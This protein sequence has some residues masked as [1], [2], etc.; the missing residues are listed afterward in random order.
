MD[1]FFNQNLQK[2]SQ[3]II[4]LITG[5]TAIIL[6]V[7]A[8][9]LML[10]ITMV[11]PHLFYIPII[12][13][14]YYFPRHGILFSITISGIYCGLVYSFNPAPGDLVPAGGRVFVFILI[15]IIVSFLTIRLRE[16][17]TR[18]RG[19]AE[20]SSDIIMLSN[21]K[22]RATYVSP[23]VKRILGYDPPEIIGRS[24]VKFIHPDDLSRL[25]ES[26]PHLIN[27]VF[28]EGI[29][30]RFRKKDGDYAILEFFGAPIIKDGTI[31]GIQIIGRD[32]TDR[33]HAEDARKETNRRLADIIAFLPDPTMVIDKSGAVVAWNHAMEL[34]SG[35]SAP[36][37]LGK[38]LE[39]YVSWI[40]GH[41][42]PVLINYVLL[43]DK[44]QIRTA[45]PNV[46]FEGNTARTQT[47]ITRIDGVRFAL[48]ISATPL[49]DRNGE[50]TGA[51]ES[52]RD[53]TDL[54]RIQHALR[55]SN[56]YLDTILNTLP[57]PLF[58]KDR[59]HKFV[60]MNDSFCH[61]TGK[62]REELL[63]KQ[64]HDFFSKDEAEIFLEKDEEV[65]RTGRE[66]ENEETLTDSSGN[67]HVI[68]TKK[69][70][71]TNTGGEKYIVGIIRDISERK[72]TELAL[73]QA[74]K[75]LNMLSSI[76]RHDILNQIIGLRIYL[77]LI[78]EREKDPELLAYAASGD[79]AADAIGHQ[80]EF[81]RY[82]EDLGVQAPRWH[83]IAELFRSAASQLPMGDIRIDVQVS[84][85]EVYTDPLIEK[86]FYNLIENSLRHGD[87]VTR[88]VLSAEENPKGILIAYCDN[89]SGISTED[90]TQLFQRGFGKHPGLGLFLSQEILSITGISITETGI[91]GEGVRFEILVPKGDYR[92]TGTS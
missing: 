12:L 14:A 61:F 31:S 51:V 27:E 72:K 86:V 17:E 29:S 67:T 34:I 70:L 4:A 5:I 23:S 9:G 90:K 2:R 25:E 6:L 75:K 91:P 19:V 49:I 80:I 68:V 36:D 89:G 41:N 21:S 77:E 62:S 47:T 73:Q 16:S 46:Y 52:L 79:A 24:P 55:E 22:G 74:L 15:A 92:F 13:A 85:L 11:L 82:Y 35:I 42:G 65:F 83:D 32:I 7:N 54:K 64:D 87:H 10:G 1:Q 78:R 56:A 45:Y 39:T 50:I 48:W 58:I 66:N 43:G 69:I 88:I 8:Y 57:D 71:Y 28:T 20:R 26:I 81:T 53:V 18:F 59:N 60:K 33:I 76:T 40:T 38:G 37:I 63:G 44:E 3:T 84:S 30:V